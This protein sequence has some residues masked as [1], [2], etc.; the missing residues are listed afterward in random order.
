MKNISVLGST[1]SI[2][3]QTLEVVRRYPDKFKVAALVGHSNVDLLEA[4][5]KE[6]KPSV[7]GISC[8]RIFSK[9]R[10]RFS[11][12]EVVGGAEALEIAAS[13]PN[14]DIVVAAV[15]GMA[16][17]MST[18]V[19]AKNGKVVALANKESLVAGGKIIM[20]AAKQNGAKVY[21]VDSEHSAV[22]QCLEG[23]NKKNL[24]KIILTASGGPLYGKTCKQLETV[25]IEQALMH[26]TWSMGRKISL[27]SA[28][29][30]NK[31]LEILE[32]SMLFDT[33][34]ID[35]VIHPESIVH[36]IVEFTDGTNLMQ[37]SPPS[38]IYPISLALTYPDRLD[39]GLN[40]FA[41]NRPL[42]F[43]PKDEINFPLPKLAKQA[44]KAHGSAPL[45]FN[46]GLEAA[47]YLFLNKKIGFGHIST[48]VAKTLESAEFVRLDS[49]EDVVKAHE[50][51]FNKVIS[52]K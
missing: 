5:V 24:S 17:F 34:N 7:V 14:V 9:E 48:I 44:L 10:H 18:L 31:A 49:A 36:S 4:Q 50:E 3:T 42:N 23:N 20:D 38:M 39:T 12:L 33:H 26:P 32:A 28:T 37:A 29:M 25:T 16:G 15:S 51:I 1:G 43:L 11:G 41:F 40:P 13:M 21:P 45:V 6:F 46:A 47:D 19:A 27:D 2:G 35:Y 30:G 22:W 52:N 8:E